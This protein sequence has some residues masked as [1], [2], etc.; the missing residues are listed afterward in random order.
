MTN[1]AK[2]TDDKSPV[3]SK[4]KAI[5]IFGNN[6]QYKENIENETGFVVERNHL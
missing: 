4:H 6:N 5:S 2:L 3:S 1:V